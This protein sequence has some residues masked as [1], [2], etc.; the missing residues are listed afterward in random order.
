MLLLYN[1]IS[2]D[3]GMGTAVLSADC[4]CVKR[5]VRDYGTS[6]LSDLGTLSIAGNVSAEDVFIRITKPHTYRL[7]ILNSIFR[8][9]DDF[10]SVKIRLSDLVKKFEVIPAIYVYPNSHRQL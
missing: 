7:D 4:F 10:L 3:C 6:S 1:L 8:R 9:R 5:L 2:V